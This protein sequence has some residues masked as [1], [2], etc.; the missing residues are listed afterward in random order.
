MYTCAIGP[1]R[2]SIDNVRFSALTCDPMARDAKR[3]IVYHDS[4]CREAHKGV[5]GATGGYVQ[6][7]CG[8]APFLAREQMITKVFPQFNLVLEGMFIQ[9]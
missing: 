3:N 6:G 8:D 1:A 9:F 5:E 2:I 7:A 4:R